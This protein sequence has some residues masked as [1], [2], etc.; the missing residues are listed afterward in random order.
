MIIWRQA[1]RGAI[2]AHVDADA[3]QASTAYQ[4]CK[5]HAN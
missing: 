2:I 3:H 5:K 4:P 1:L